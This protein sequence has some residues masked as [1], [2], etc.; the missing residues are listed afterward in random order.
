MTT[1]SIDSQSW[2]KCELKCE[3]QVGLCKNRTPA[4]PKSVSSVYIAGTCW[5]L[6]NPYGAGRGADWDFKKPWAPARPNLAPQKTKK[7]KKKPRF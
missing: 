3:V 5:I 6:T 1:Y 4:P 2:E 7:K